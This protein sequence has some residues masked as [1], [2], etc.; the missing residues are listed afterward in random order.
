MSGQDEL[1][2]PTP[3]EA[4]YIAVLKS[5]EFQGLR[6]R[7]RRWVFPVTIA[8][9]LW[10]ILYVLLAAYAA[11]FMANRCWATS[12][13]AWCSVCC[14][15]SRHSSITGLY[16]RYAGRVLDPASTLIREKMEKEGL[17]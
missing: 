13:S 3:T 11:D 14:S 9:L 15:S 10:Y 17:A 12:M 7:Y 4:K 8:A 5:P 6:K 2:P 16:V 1:P